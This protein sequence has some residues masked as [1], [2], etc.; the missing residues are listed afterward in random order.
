MNIILAPDSFKGS[1]SATAAVEYMARG[2]S[3]IM[4]DARITKLP[5]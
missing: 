5:L 2:T 3:E 1:L 4:P